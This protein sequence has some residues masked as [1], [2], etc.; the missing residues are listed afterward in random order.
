MRMISHIVTSDYCIRPTFARLPQHDVRLRHDDACGSGKRHMPAQHIRHVRTTSSIVCMADGSRAPPKLSTTNPNG[1]LP[2]PCRYGLCSSRPAH[3][4]DTPN[5]ENAA[6]CLRPPWQLQL[7]RVLQELPRASD[8]A[9]AVPG[10]RAW[11]EARRAAKPPVEARILQ[12]ILDASEVP[13]RWA[14]CLIRVL[15]HI[16]RAHGCNLACCS[17]AHCPQVSRHCVLINPRVQQY[18]LSGPEQLRVGLRSLLTHYTR[19]GAAH[20]A[21]WDRRPQLLFLVSNPRLG[22]MAKI[23]TQFLRGGAAHPT[24][25]DRRAHQGGLGDQPAAARR[26]RLLHSQPRHCGRCECKLKFR[27]LNFQAGVGHKPAA[28]C[29][30]PPRLPASPLQQ[31]QMRFLL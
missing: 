28:A 27:S 14:I 15:W 1:H 9:S 26:A 3:Q 31:V 20:A 2:S 21:A 11:L 16:C 12:G 7:Q 19:G 17:Q 24:A 22:H 8:L 5:H 29:R 10:M 6:P 18:T 30:A 25:C 23:A 4:P 13:Y